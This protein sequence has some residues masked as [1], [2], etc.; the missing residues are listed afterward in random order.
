M[1]AAWGIER[2]DATQHDRGDFDCGKPSLNAWLSDFAS[3]Y[4][5]KNL[6]RTYVA[7][8]QG[9]HVVRGYYSVASHHVLYETLPQEQAKGLARRQACPVRVARKAG[10]MQER[11]G[12]RAWKTIAA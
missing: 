4:E 2:F 3:Q 8:L 12:A 1:G 11:S 7:T 6:A 9:E 10:S 5:R